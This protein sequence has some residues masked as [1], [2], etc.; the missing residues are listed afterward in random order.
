MAL[1][2][3]R[4]AEIVV[5]AQYAGP[6][7]EDAHRLARRTDWAEQP[8]GAWVG[9]GQRLWLLG[10]EA[11]GVLDIGEITFAAPNVARPT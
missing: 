4:V 5:P 8:G 3:G 10:E 1:H 6:A 9:T 2:D 7:A 11:Q